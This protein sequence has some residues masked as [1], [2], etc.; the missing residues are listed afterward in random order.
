MRCNRSE[1]LFD[2]LLDGTLTPLECR[3]VERHLDSCARCSSVLEELRVID[4]LLLSPRVLEPAPNFTF[5]MMAEIRA[6]PAPTPQRVHTWLW[7]G[8]YLLL[9]WAA[10]GAWVAFGRPD[11]HA[12]LVLG[13]GFWQHFSGAVLGIGRVLA[14][15]Y[16][17]AIVAVVLCVD[18]ALVALAFA[19]PRL[20][21]RIA[22]SESA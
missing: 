21:A 10:I 1:V 11:A 9:S 12:A 18:V 19:A 20:I 8:M 2:G 3:E 6:V 17:A 4:A 14:N 13:L 16:L 7:L 22:Q 15:G 5:K